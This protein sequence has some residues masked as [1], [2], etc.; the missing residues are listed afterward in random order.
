MRPSSVFLRHLL[1]M[2]FS[3]A[4]S[5]CAGEFEEAVQALNTLQT[6]A[7][8]L[9]KIKTERDKKRF[10]SIPET[11]SQ[12]NRVGITL[13]DID[14]LS[15]IHV[16]GTK[17]KGSTCAF[18]E[19][20]LRCHGFRTGFFSSPHLVEVQERIRINGE[21]LGHEAFSRYFW[22]CFNSLQKTKTTHDASMPPYFRFLTIMAFHVFLK[23][24]VDVAIMEVGIGGEYDCTNIVR[25][26]VVCGVSSLGL[27]HTSILGDTIEKIAWHKAGIF[28]PGVPAVTV[29]QP[30][31]AI[32][33]LMKRASEIKCPLYVA[34][35]FEEYSW[36]ESNHAALGIP[37][38]MQALNAS[39]ALQL[40]HTW[41]ENHHKCVEERTCFTGNNHGKIS[42]GKIL[43]VTKVMERGLAATSWLG[44]NQTIYHPDLTFYI[45]GAHTPRSIEACVDWFTEA[46]AKEA[47]KLNK[48]VVRVLLFNMTGDR[49][50][51]SLLDPL[52][53]CQFDCAVFCP[54]I[55]T[56]T[57]SNADQT[58]LTVSLNSQLEKCHENRRCFLS[59]LKPAVNSQQLSAQLGQTSE[60]VSYESEDSGI[61]SQRS[62]PEVETIPTFTFQSIQ[63]ALDWL[64][65]DKDSK[66]RRRPN[67]IESAEHI[68]VLCTGSLHLIGGIL[69]LTGTENIRR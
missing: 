31:N 58:N 69:S 52:L 6:N 44:R 63:E 67:V 12:A 53:V 7:V 50:A 15:V 36:Q 17:G 14:R 2:S 64:S 60:H 37:G 40:S 59:L 34:P 35:D 41:L 3:K 47:K 26:P 38:K 8:V 5:S 57:L 46:S 9:E 18:T 19:R 24:E 51:E 20:I 49:K 39:L 48:R 23:E 61:D 66:S 30:D 29:P 1:S 43:T 21:P 32:D 11:I 54:N 28:K 62:S 25:F 65:Q 42:K 45:D 55:A 27:D 16:S 4:T 13:E 56:W 10:L 68:Q 33:V 22:E